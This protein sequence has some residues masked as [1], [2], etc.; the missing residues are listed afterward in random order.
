MI[1]PRWF[2]E[3]WGDTLQNIV[4]QELYLGACENV[5]MVKKSAEGY[6]GKYMTKSGE[7]VAKVKEDGN[8]WMLPHQWWFSTA[9]M[10][11]W[12]RARMSCGQATGQ[13]LDSLVYEALL[14]DSLPDGLWIRPILIELTDMSFHAGWIGRLSG[15][16]KVDIDNIR[17]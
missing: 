2:R 8:E 17:L 13:L 7:E 4:G 1:P 11:R 9:E 3:K 16:L 12:L 5:Q 14:E 15:H 6:L 10:K